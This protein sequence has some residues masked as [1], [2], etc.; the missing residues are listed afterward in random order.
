MGLSMQQVI[1][2]NGWRL[3]SLSKTGSAVRTIVLTGATGLV[4]SHFLF[5]K[6]RQPG[7]VFVLAGGDSPE[8]GRERVLAALQQCAA[9]YNLP[10]PDEDI[11]HKLVVL[12]GQLGE[13][14]CRLSAHAL[15]TLAAAG[16][17]EFWHCADSRQ[18]EDRYRDEIARHNLD[19][20][21]NVLELA[22]HAGAHR[23]LHLSTVYSSGK[24]NGDIPEALL[25]LEI[26]Y[27]NFY[28]ESKN[29]AEHLVAGFCSERG[30]DY[31]IL[32][33]STVIGPLISHRNGGHYGIYGF[34]R[35]LFRLRDTLARI[36]PPLRLTMQHDAAL[37]LTPV[38]ECVYDMLTL[39]QHGDSQQRVFH[40]CNPSELAID[41][42]LRR[43][44]RLIG[45]PLLTAVQQRDSAATLLE[46]VLD[47]RIRFY[48]GY[49]H[50]RKRL[51]R[52]APAQAA[53]NWHDFELYLSAYRQEFQ[54]QQGSQAGFERLQL[55]ARD[56][57][58]L[59]V[60]RLGAAELPPLLLVNG[61]GMPA[62]FMLPLALRLSST[63]RVYTWES[64]W[65]PTLSHPFQPGGCDV[66]VHV[67]DLADILARYR[68]SDLPLVAWGSG[69][70]ISL[71]A[72]AEH[73]QQLRCAVLLEPGV[74]LAQPTIQH[75]R[76]EVG[77]RTLLPK[78]AGSF[79]MAETYC[80]LIYGARHGNVEE[81]Q[82]LSSIIASTDPYLLYL[83]SLPYRSPEALYRYANMMTGLFRRPCD[84]WLRRIEQPVLV[85]VS[86]DNQLAHPD[87]G[88]AVSS[89][90]AHG[91]L[92]SVATGGHF[93]HFYQAEV[94]A[95][96]R[97]FIAQTSTA[98]TDYSMQ[99]QHA[100]RGAS[101]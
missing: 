15:A 39:D 5:W 46:D 99:E 83:S 69:S 93:S 1:R 30:I 50:S 3:L 79:R 41:E 8:H 78:I 9:A 29:R 34:A 26:E 60:F 11:A 95:G 42:M 52:S 94:A 31:R 84:E 96:I 4:G 56:G 35:E 28:E 87:I 73:K 64:R 100:T 6:I 63:F 86:E 59:C 91:T 49:L 24:L 77:L 57:V 55:R 44:S 27:N 89:K 2:E 98:A 65:V 74:T 68:L 18:F 13:P 101:S 20:T 40:L 58:D 51:A 43:L 81:R 67:D 16:V 90:L 10:L 66:Q 88:R 72:L 14:R 12:H 97:R 19:G 17:D 48:A 70:H 33:S 80:E 45:Q 82:R 32:R 54:A 7:R 75:T 37:N 22:V 92:E 71:A 25:P 76:Y 61:Y 85:R 62:D 38:D 53:L 36:D 23:F 21:R 47:Q